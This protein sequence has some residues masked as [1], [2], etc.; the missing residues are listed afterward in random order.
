MKTTIQDNMKKFTIN[1]LIQ[2][3]ISLKLIDGYIKSDLL[4][5][6]MKYFPDPF[7]SEQQSQIFTITI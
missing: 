2:V 3:I 5:V 1:K 7:Y 4:E 6:R